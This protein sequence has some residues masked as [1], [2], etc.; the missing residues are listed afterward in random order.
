MTS[1][2]NQ[3][4]NIVDFVIEI[5]LHTDSTDIDN[6][7]WSA[8]FAYLQVS[9]PRPPAITG[10]L[11]LFRESV[12]SLPM[13]KHETVPVITMDQPLYAIAKKGQW[14]WPAAYGENKLVVLLGGLHIEIA[15]LAVMGDWLKDSGWTSVMSAANV[16]TDGRA[17][18]I[19]KGS[20][21]EWAPQVTGAALHILQQRAFQLYQE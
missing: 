13:V 4:F 21:G 5:N 19:L 17:D 18:A 8:H 9:V 1:Q 15:V 7:S 3:I 2:F 16:T 11:P 12:H 20:Q 14:S 6:I 10:L